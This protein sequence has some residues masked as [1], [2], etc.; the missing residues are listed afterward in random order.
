VRK[1]GIGKYSPPSA[2]QRNDGVGLGGGKVRQ[3]MSNAP[4]NYGTEEVPVW[5]CE[6]GCPVKML[7]EMSGERPPGRGGRMLAGYQDVY[8]GGKPQKILDCPGYTDKGMV[9]RYFY[10]AKASRG[11]REAGLQ[12]KL[13]C[14][15]CGE[16]N[17]THH[18]DDKGR[19][20][21]C[22]RNPHPTVKPIGITEYL[23]R[24]LLPPEE[25]R[26]KATILICFSGTG[27]EIIGAIKAGWRNWLAV[28][29]DEGMCEIARARIEHWTRQGRLL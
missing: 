7:D 13:P 23:A 8:V 2:R 9:S 28:E 16:L 1:V 20:V 12:G 3:G 5:E 27:S 10:Q 11:E 21:K 15:K 29:M 25:Y 26:D 6:D 19:K 18:I 24:L 17:S 4:D 14:V 22:I